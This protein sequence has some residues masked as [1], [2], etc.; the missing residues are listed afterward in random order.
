MVEKTNQPQKIKFKDIISMPLG[1]LIQS[2]PLIVL[3]L[4]LVLFFASETIYYNLN[5]NLPGFQAPAMDTWPISK[6]FNQFEDQKGN[7][8]SISYENITNSTFDGL[9]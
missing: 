9:V 5:I 1:C 3:I 8:W 4:G 7:V 2:S 6:G